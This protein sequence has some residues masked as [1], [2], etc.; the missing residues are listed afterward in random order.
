M[1]RIKTEIY[2]SSWLRRCQAEGAFAAVVKKGDPD[3]G[4]IIV[5]T[6]GEGN[7]AQAFIE[8]Y[9]DSDQKQ[10]RCM[11][12]EPMAESEVDQLIA[13]E[14]KFDRDLWVVEVQDR[15]GRHFLD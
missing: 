5:K 2:V 13:Q 11:N 7:A 12:E 3:A 15:A 6:I 1:L 4:I 10:W 14:T 8:Q 9:S